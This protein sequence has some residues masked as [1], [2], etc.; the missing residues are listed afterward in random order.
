MEIASII[1]R[2]EDIERS[3]AFWSEVVGLSVAK[4][5]SGFASMDGGRVPLLLSKI[6]S[7]RTDESLTEIVFESEDVRNTYQ[8]MTERGVPFERELR[9]VMANDGGTDRSWKYSPMVFLATVGRLFS[10]PSVEK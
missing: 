7:S 5:T 8:A 10:H 9:P 4:Q 2:V 6:D 3:I 1:L